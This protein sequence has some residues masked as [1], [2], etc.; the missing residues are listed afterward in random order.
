[1]NLFG[2]VL[3][4]NGKSQLMEGEQKESINRKSPKKSPQENLKKSLRA[5]KNNFSLVTFI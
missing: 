2:I 3:L 4:V 1:M 5:K